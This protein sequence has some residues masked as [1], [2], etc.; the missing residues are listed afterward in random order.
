[1]GDLTPYLVAGIVASLVG[2]FTFLV[3]H[4]FWI[5]PIWFI[6]PVG[7]ALA[8]IG[9]IAVGW[10]YEELHASLPS[11]PWTALALA[12]IIAAILAPAILLAE[13]RAP[14]VDPVTLAILP[15][16]GLR[17]TTRFFLELLVPAAAV[18]AAAGWFLTHSSRAAVATAVAGLVYALGPGH[19]IPLLGGTASAGK[20]LLLLLAITVAATVT[21]VETNALLLKK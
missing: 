6:L 12:A 18:G 21:L 5:Q 11:R 14:L 4:H 17:A 15:G 7:L 8:A 3:I 16:Q 19:N 9:G 13:L 10:S 1:M 2:L 20:G